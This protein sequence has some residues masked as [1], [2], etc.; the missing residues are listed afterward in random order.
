MRL[1]AQSAAFH[2]LVVICT[3]LLVSCSAAQMAVTDKASRVR[4]GR[5]A[6]SGGFQQ[7][8]AITAQHGGGCGAYGARGN[9]EGAY[10]V[11]KNRAAD[12]GAEYV[13]ILR[14]TEPRLEGMCMNQAFIIDGLAYKAG[15]GVSAAVAPARSQGLNGTYSGEITG[16]TQGRVFKVRISFTLVQSEEAIIGTWTTTGGASGT[17]KGILTTDGIRELTALQVQPCHGEYVAL[18]V[19]DAGGT[20]L[21]GSY[22]GGDCSGA[23]TASFRVE[24]Q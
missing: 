8:G 2:A 6:P 14:V 12:L 21:S 4:V 15:A 20:R 3:A 16:N 18:A 17:L 23:L 7:V 1:L 13:Q 5:E 9:F 11:L 10:A 22:I 24:R 19:I